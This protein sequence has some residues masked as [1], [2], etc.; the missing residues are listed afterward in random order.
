M[1]APSRKHVGFPDV[2]SYMLHV[3]T[4]DTH[5]V[6]IALIKLSPHSVDFYFTLR[7]EIL[8]VFVEY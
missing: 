8:E 5:V 3:L 2:Q 4:C 6:S 1:S 7:K